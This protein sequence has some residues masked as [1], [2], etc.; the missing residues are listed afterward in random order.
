MNVDLVGPF[1]FYLAISG[2]KVFFCS[3]MLKT[4]ESLC[5]ARPVASLNDTLHKPSQWAALINSLDAH[6][7]LRPRW[8]SRNSDDQ[9]F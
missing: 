2:V 7:Q 5:L 6:G 1:D 4:V 9:V 8:E 3:P